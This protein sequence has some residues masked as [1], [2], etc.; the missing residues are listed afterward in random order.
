MMKDCQEG[1]GVSLRLRETCSRSRR[2]LSQVEETVKVNWGSSQVSNGSVE[3]D[4]VGHSKRIGGVG[5]G[6]RLYICAMTLYVPR[7]SV[8]SA[9]VEA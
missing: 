2:G 8:I 9:L 5:L 3:T 4:I 6:P 7:Q 1:S